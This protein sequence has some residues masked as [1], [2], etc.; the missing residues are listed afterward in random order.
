M[1]EK[2]R[3]SKSLLGSGAPEQYA[4]NFEE[5]IGANIEALRNK[6]N[7]AANTVGQQ[8]RDRGTEALDKAR[9]LARGMDSMGQRMAE[10]S[11]QQ[12]NGGQQ[13]QQGKDGQQGQAGK[14]GQQGQPGQS[15]QQGKP[16]QQGQGQQGQ[17]GQQGQSGQQGGQGGQQGGNNNGGDMGGRASLGGFG[18][19]GWNGSDRRPGNFS[20]DDIRQF[21]GEARRWAQEGQALRNMLREQNI[22]PKE[23]DEIMKRLREL[24]SERVYQDVAELE[25]LQTFVAEGMKRFEYG[26]RRQAGDETDRALVNGSDEVPAEFKALVEEYYRSLSRTKPRQ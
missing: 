20:P 19:G 7:D 17:G 25:R 5:E 16:G 4:R 14:P 13:G 1:K 21:R 15:G 11:R 18:D 10:R 23:L 26:L 24:D 2:I 22:D 6:L 8:G 12:A 9:E 3:Y